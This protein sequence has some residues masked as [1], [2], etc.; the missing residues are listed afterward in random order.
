MNRLAGV[1]LLLALFTLMGCAVHR[2]SQPAPAQPA[3]AAPPLRPAEPLPA[4]PMR[5]SE[6]SPQQHNAE[7]PVFTQTGLASFYAA[8]FHGNKTAS[9]DRYDKAGFTAAHRTLAFGMI[10]RVTNTANGRSVKVQVNDRGPHV[11]N[12]IIDLSRAAARALG[13]RHGVAH[14]RLEVFRSDQAPG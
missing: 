12:R 3:P 8:R 2:P 11:K 7:E 10:V 13:I 5:P 4:P 9:G 6:V 14:V 1:T